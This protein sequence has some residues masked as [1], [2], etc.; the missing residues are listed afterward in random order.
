MQLWQT[1][2]IEMYTCFELK[3]LRFVW[4]YKMSQ[5]LSCST[6]SNDRNLHR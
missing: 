5:Q 2:I 1:D 4:N 6:I 3:L